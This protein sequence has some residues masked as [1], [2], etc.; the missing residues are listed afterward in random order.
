[1]MM[2]MIIDA[3]SAAFI[4]EFA[5]LPARSRG[6]VR[7]AIYDLSERRSKRCSMMFASIARLGHVI[8]CCNGSGCLFLRSCGHVRARSSLLSDVRLMKFAFGAW[9]IKG[10]RGCGAAHGKKLYRIVH[11]SN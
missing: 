4:N 8:V 3:T 11:L 10:Y 5:Y 7:C 2:T 1:M 9:L 6:R